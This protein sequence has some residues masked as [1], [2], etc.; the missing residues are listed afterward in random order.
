MAP[1]VLLALLL[2][3]VGTTAS[4][5]QNGA[6]HGTFSF[7]EHGYQS[8]VALKSNEAMKAYI[9]QALDRQHRS[10][11]DE[12]ALS[13]FTQY[14]SGVISSQSWERLQQELATAAWTVPERVAQDAPTKADVPSARKDRGK[15]AIKESQGGHRLSFPSS[16]NVSSKV[17][18]AKPLATSHVAAVA[19]ASQTPAKSMVLARG[20][21]APNTSSGSSNH[22]PGV[23][24]VM[25]HASNTLEDFSAQA[26]KMRRRVAEKQA[27]S[28]AELVALKSQYVATLKAQAEANKGIEESNRVCEAEITTLKAA[29]EKTIVKAEAFQKSIVDMRDAMRLLSGKVAMSIGFAQDSIGVTDLSNDSSVKVLIPVEPTPTLESYLQAARVELGPQA[30][31]KDS[32]VVSDLGDYASLLQ[33]DGQSKGLSLP[34]HDPEYEQLGTAGKAGAFLSVV[35]KSFESLDKAQEAGRAVLKEHFTRKHQAGEARR[36]ALLE[37]QAALNGQR[38][39]LQGKEALLMTALRNLR[40]IH[41]ELRARMESFV[42][43]ATK[44]ETTLK[45]VTQGMPPGK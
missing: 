32:V 23:T 10:V 35:T 3:P 21:A 31:S 44:M 26:Q 33:T 17:A 1:V 2:F 15:D 45:K 4:N 38:E 27:E 25:T 19:A 11:L 30:R 29:T 20:E 43:F 14:Y 36:S 16:S 42:G 39:A 12:G 9:R 37:I 8:V 22:L 40:D 6:Q 34:E 41:Y 13:G 5:F 18:V 28:K 7:D 24:E